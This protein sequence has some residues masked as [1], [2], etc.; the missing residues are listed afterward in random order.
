MTHQPRLN[1][2][3][4]QGVTAMAGL[5]LALLAPPCLLASP[6]ST[7]TASGRVPPTASVD[8]PANPI[9]EPPV[10]AGDGS[11]M[12]VAIQD[13]V[14]IYASVPSLVALS[15]LQLAAPQGVN[16]S[17][18][19]AEIN[20][21]ANGSRLLGA[22]TGGGGAISFPGGAI[23]AR[24]SARFYSTTPRP[25]PAGTYTAITVLSVVAD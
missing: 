13:P 5:L 9:S 24:I 2:Y 18:V 15:P 23:A 14:Q 7:I 10:L 6:N 8:L 19:G 4:R 22:S 12:S 20:L 11:E 16:P 17:E 1:R 21:T 3:Y 25:L